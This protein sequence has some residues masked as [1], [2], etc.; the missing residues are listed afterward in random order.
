MI[1]LEARA[2]ER[3]LHLTLFHQR[4]APLQVVETLSGGNELK[5]A[6]AL[7]E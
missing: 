6:R 7:A 4:C 2:R 1:A 3:K 5:E